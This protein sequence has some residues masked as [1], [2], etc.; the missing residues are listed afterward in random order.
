MEPSRGMEATEKG[1]SGEVSRVY[2]PESWIERL[3]FLG[4]LTEDWEPVSRAVLTVASA[5][6]AVFLIQAARGSALATS[7]DLV[8]VPIHEGGHLLFRFFGEFLYVA[9]GTLMQVGVPF[10]L[11]I[12]FVLRRQ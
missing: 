5:F 10:L 7:M 3:P 9:G 8:F 4:S 2:L 12:H 1:S 11:A 6:Y